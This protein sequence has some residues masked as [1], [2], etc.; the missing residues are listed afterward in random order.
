MLEG[1]SSG[2]QLWWHAFTGKDAEDGTI[3]D[4]FIEFHLLNPEDRREKPVFGTGQVRKVGGRKTAQ[5]QKPSYLM[6]KAGSWGSGAA[7]MN[8]FWGFNKT[9]MELGRP[10]SI[11]AGDCY[12]DLTG[13][14]GSVGISEE[15]V[16]VHREWMTD[17]GTMAWS[18]IMERKDACPS[19]WART[20]Y[21]GVVDFGGRRYIVEP[22]ACNGTSGCVWGGGF[23]L[24][25]LRLGTSCIKGGG[26]GNGAM[27]A[28][29]DNGFSAT[30][31]LDG[32]RMDFDG[33]GPF[34]SV[35]VDCRE[36]KKIVIWHIEQRSIRGRLVIDITCSKK[37][38]L[39]LTHEAPDGSKMPPRLWSGGNGRGKM[40]FKRAGKTLWSVRTD[41]V[42][43]LW[44][45]KK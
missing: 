27:Q 17:A 7:Q 12:L 33:A 4:F 30:I 11:S 5:K 31:W 23:T 32:R 15:E 26:I 13:T 21:E 18:L 25:V 8:R 2:Y 42:R 39:L 38:M 20:S 44:S 14:H 45:G 10:F 28:S 6:V 37:D 16:S 3:R 22:S 19:G 43:C 34:R 40:E 24:P 29:L 41:G 1:V 9:E 35:K 36:A